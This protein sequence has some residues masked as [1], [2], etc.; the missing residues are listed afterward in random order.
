M[1]EFCVWAVHDQRCYCLGESGET[2][3]ACENRFKYYSSAELIP[4]FGCPTDSR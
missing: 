2:E 4:V 3:V 1:P